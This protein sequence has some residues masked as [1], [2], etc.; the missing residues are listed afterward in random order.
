MSL[1]ITDRE[2]DA[3][4]GQ[5][6]FIMALYIQL[7][8]F[9]DSCT[10]IVGIKRGISYQSLTEEL[11]QEPE[12]GDEGGSPSKWSIRR[13]LK[14]MQRI[15]LLQ[16]LPYPDNLVFKCILAQQGKSVPKKAA[17]KPP[18]LEQPLTPLPMHQ[19]EKAATPLLSIKP[20]VIVTTTTT[21]KAPD[22]SS[23]FSDLIFPKRLDDISMASMQRL[24]KDFEPDQQQELLDELTGYIERGKVQSTPTAL[25]FGMVERY[26]MGAFNPR[27]AGKVKL[28]RETAALQP[29]VKP[30]MTEADREKGRAA[31]SN[32]RQLFGKKKKP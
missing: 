14:R 22:R 31:M 30:A 32:V 9:M 17:T 20:S 8:R 4:E 26:R 25:L 18:Y 15:G 3:L 28:S 12:K 1:L 11:Y 13:A 19:S 10:C 24:L 27:F 5:P 16:R 6:L 21:P 29:E 23:S 2:L 7:R